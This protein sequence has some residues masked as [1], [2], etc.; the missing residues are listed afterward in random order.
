MRRANVSG[1]I[2]DLTVMSGF[3]VEFEGASAKREILRPLEPDEPDTECEVGYSRDALEPLT[4]VYRNRKVE[5]TPTLYKLFRYV[6]DI[7]RMQ[8][9]TEFPFLE[10]AVVLEG[11]TSDQAITKQIRRLGEFL[12]EID[13]P[14]SLIPKQSTL[15]VEDK[16]V[17]ESWDNFVPE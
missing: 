16:I 6:N 7:Y 4:I 1:P 11:E 3:L 14:I 8:E 9:Q 13:S 17:P 12:K 15:Y 5:L 10:L 2:G